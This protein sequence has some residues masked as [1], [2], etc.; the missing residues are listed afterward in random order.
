MGWSQSLHC[1]WT[2]GDAEPSLSG[3]DTINQSISHKWFRKQE[4]NISW[5]LEPGR[6]F[7][8]QWVRNQWTS[9]RDHAEL[10]PT[11]NT[12]VS[13]SAQPTMDGWP[14]KS[15]M[16]VWVSWVSNQISCKAESR[17][18]EWEDD[19]KSNEITREKKKWSKREDQRKASRPDGYLAG[20]WIWALWTSRRQ[21]YRGRHLHCHLSCFGVSWPQLSCCGTC[22]GESKAC[23]SHAS[24]HNSG[25]WPKTSKQ[26][27][28][29]NTWRL[30]LTNV[31]KTTQG[32]T[33]LEKTCNMSHNVQPEKPNPNPNSNPNLM[34]M[35][36]K[37]NYEWKSL[38]CLQVTTSQCTFIAKRGGV[39]LY[40]VPLALCASGK[41]TWSGDTHI[42]RKVVMVIGWTDEATASCQASSPLVVH[43]VTLATKK[44]IGLPEQSI[45]KG[46]SIK[47]ESPRLD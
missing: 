9:L 39:A 12:W 46:L 1:Q 26:K 32:C 31:S 13:K 16:G 25:G 17:S 35:S 37:T 14:T 4:P 24:S 28:A 15:E 11:L 27:V 44:R 10:E 38:S 36:L 6:R 21:R 8:E 40:L 22:L 45:Q 33:T 23:C 20:T 34:N 43:I 29:G 5:S 41:G 30:T 18:V 42:Q 7:C 47:Y 19:T 2:G 3:N